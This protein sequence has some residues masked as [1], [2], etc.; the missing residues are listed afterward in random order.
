L[1]LFDENQGKNEHFW[2]RFVRFGLEK[3]FK[4]ASEWK[5]PETNPCRYGNK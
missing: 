2:E 5:I 1:S 4:S 3:K